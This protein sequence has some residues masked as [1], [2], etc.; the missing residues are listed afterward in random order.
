MASLVILIGNMLAQAKS[1]PA[2]LRPNIIFLMSDDQGWGD[3][4]YNG[5]PI[6]RTPNL[7]AFAREGVRLDRFYAAA[8]VCS[9]TRGSVI[10]G[11]HP[12]RYSINWASEGAIPAGEVTLAEAL[13]DAGYRTGHFG[14]WHLGLL[15]RTVQQGRKPPLNPSFYS[16]P[17]DNGFT[18]CFSTEGNM[19]TFNPYYYTDA[20]NNYDLILK[21]DA[22]SVGRAH[23][24]KESY[25]MSEGHSLERAPEG[26]DSRIIMDRAL[27]FITAA[28]GQPFF[29]CV[30]FHAPHTPIAAGR[31]WRK[32][33]AQLS[34]EEQH[35]Y[36]T[37]SAMD[38]QVGRLRA[39]LRRRGLAENTLVVFFS[40]NGPTYAHPYGSS[41]PFRGRKASL[42]EGGIRVPAVVE[43]PRGLA[44]GRV[45]DT[46]VVTS[47]L[48]PTVIAL[49]G[50]ATSRQ[51]PLDGIDV[52]PIL[53]GRQT[54]RGYPIFFQSPLKNANDPWARPDTYQ[55]AVET[56]RY[57][58]LTLDSGKSWIY[59]D[60]ITDRAE[61]HDLAASHAEE[62][63][64]L[65]A[66][67]N[68]WSDSCAQ[69]A[70]GA[71]YR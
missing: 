59:Y 34:L 4:A 28:G 37:I 6:V 14:K 50:T 35:W 18:T 1:P 51:P 58:F 32:P 48:Y 36:G 46:P 45:I 71:D 60:V 27:D 63:L 43:W 40:D 54:K 9:P 70:R 61:Q 20:A 49:T 64:A 33:Y 2:D 44:G 11:R 12:S 8:P 39:E 23:R 67:L 53:Q 56:D 21:Q 38:A 26:D 3:V 47:D 68:Q 17:W 29:A 13:R 24:W 42:L 57:K 31:D 7:D 62:V 19:P 22:E 25:W 69:S 15:S 52:F 30:W 66:Q 10:T 55:A 16:P 41:G 5:H 65:R